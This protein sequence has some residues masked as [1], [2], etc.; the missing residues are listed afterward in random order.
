ME[1]TTGTNARLHVADPTARRENGYT[2]RM[3]A[4][5]LLCT[6]LLAAAAAV[7]AQPYRLTRD[8][9]YGT[10][11]DQQGNTR[12]LKL[13]LYEPVDSIL[14]SA[15]LRPTVVWIHGGAWRAGDKYPAPAA[16]TN[17]CANGY[18]VASINYRLT[19][20][21]TWPAQI[22][23][24]RG[25]LRFLRSRSAQ[26]R[27]DKNRVAVWGSSA[28]GHLAAILGA[29]SGL[30]QIKIDGQTFDLEGEIGGNLQESSAVQA[31]VDY[32][33]PADLLAFDDFQSVFPDPENNSP[34][35]ELIGGL[36]W[37]NLPLA[38]SAS[39]DTYV[40]A[41][42]PPVLM[43]HGTS[44]V[45]VPF[46]QSERY[47]A[48]LS[49]AN[50]H[51]VFIPIVGGG[52]G[53]TQ[54]MSGT[55]LSAVYAFLRRFLEGDANR[56][57]LPSISLSTERGDVPFTVSAS[58]AGS[59]DPDGQLIARYWTFGENGGANGESAQFAYRNV[60]TFPITLTVVDNAGGATT[61]ER[62]VVASVAGAT[63]A[64]IFRVRAPS[65]RVFEASARKC[66]QILRVNGAR[67]AVRVRYETV[68]GSARGGEDFVAT[69]GE[70]T[71]EDGET[72]RVVRIT[73]LPDNRNEPDEV[74]WLR[75]TSPAGGAVLGPPTTVQLTILDDD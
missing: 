10:W 23:D 34:L 17:L 32:F 49:Q 19:Q 55:P 39:P 51:R 11:R 59:H 26:Y 27:I 69:S 3:A 41:E 74:F 62:F 58:S 37:D 1:Y 66:I 61:I 7:I 71:F 4:R 6:L 18:V 36:V 22:H 63:D 5:A 38:R 65:V 57:P 72:W 24:C 30:K 64:G 33:G 13:D 44:D 21:G 25:A 8:I 43:M 15:L 16:V 50:V 70:L 68:D 47:N 35:T 9:T 56:L 12:E 14:Y 2:P 67:G 48:R 40:S 45:V 46:N 52:H 54:F 60:G 20:Q 73:M 29:T 53:G 28:G 31:V 75:L 42:D